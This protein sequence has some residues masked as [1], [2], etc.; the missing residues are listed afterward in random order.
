MKLRAS[1]VATMTV[2]LL[3]QM[4]PV[5]VQ[6]QDWEVPVYG[7]L[8]GGSS[9][10]RLTKKKVFVNTSDAAFNNVVLE[11]ITALDYAFGVTVPVYFIN[12]GRKNAFFT[13]RKFASLIAEDRADPNMAVTGSVFIGF[14]LIHEE[15]KETNG[16]LM[17]IPAILGHEFAHA[18]QYKNKFP[19]EGKWRELHADYLAGWFIGHRGRFR[20]QNAFQAFLNFY[21]KGDHD[22]FS[23][24]HHGTPQE[25]GTAFNAGYLLNVRGNE[26]SAINAYNAG[27]QYVR[28]LGA[29]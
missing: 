10:A 9:T 2:V 28:Y 24:D 20:P 16:T 5:F 19:Y 26:P 14:T 27:L 23:E 7:C 4:F 13:P 11:D 25:R 6:A 17:S 22:F 29:R 18:M 3:L 8:A 12:D 15:Y 1:I 21:K